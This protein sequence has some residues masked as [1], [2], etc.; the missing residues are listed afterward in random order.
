MHGECRRKE[1]VKKGMA[2]LLALCL[3]CGYVPPAGIVQA[4][5]AAADIPSTAHVNDTATAGDTAEDEVEDYFSIRQQ[6]EAAGH[7]MPEDISLSF[8]IEAAAQSGPLQQALYEGEAGILTD[9]AQPWVEFTVDIPT[10]GLYQLGSRYYTDDSRKTAPIRGLLIDGVSPYTEAQSIAFYSQFRDESAPRTNTLGDE[11][12]PQATA[13]P[14]WK[15]NWFFDSTGSV[16]SPLVFYMEQGQHVIRLDMVN[17][18]P[19]VIG[20]LIVASVENPPS[21]AEYRQMH[22]STN[23]GAYDKRFEAEDSM[24]YRN[25]SAVTLASHGDPRVS[26]SSVKHQVLNTVGGYTFRRGGQEVI[27]EVEAPAAGYY[28]LNFRVLQNF[29]GWQPSYRRITVNGTVPFAELESYAFAYNK[30]WYNAILSAPDGTPY[31]IWLE[32]G[33]NEIGLTVNFGVD[34]QVVTCFTDAIFALS[35]LV[36]QITMITGVSPDPNYNYRLDDNIPD[37]DEQFAAILALLEEARELLRSTA[38]HTTTMEDNIDSVAV[39][40]EKIRRR[41]DDIPGQL[42]NLSDSANSLGDW[43]TDLQSQALQIDY[44]QVCSPDVEIPEYHSNIFEVIWATL[45]SFAQS[46]TRDYDYIAAVSQDGE[47]PVREV[48]DVWIGRGTEWAEILKQRIDSDFTPQTGIAVRLNM[49]P[50]GQLS[51]GQLNVLLLAISSGNAPDVAMSVASNLPV[52]YAIRGAVSDLSAFEGYDRIA[53]RFLEQSLVPYQYDGG[54]WGM[55]ETMGFRVMF[56]RKDIFEDLSL[57]PPETWDELYNT[58]IPRLFETGRQVYVP[59]WMD[60]FVL[61]NGG[62]YYTP[63]GKRSALNTPE[64]YRGFEMYCNTYTLYGVPTSANFFNRFRQGEMPIG[65]EG[66]GMY[67]SLTSAAPE[68]NGLWG[69]TQIPGVRMEDGTVNR[70]T[71]GYAGEA[72][73]IL[74][75]SAKQQASFDFLNWWTSTEVQSEYASQVLSRIGAQARWMSANVEAFRSASWD[76]AH[77]EVITDSW[78]NLQEIPNVLGGYFT[79]RDVGN[80]WNRVILN[81]MSPRDSLELC[82]EDINKELTRRQ[83]QYAGN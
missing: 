37:L 82:Y 27:F 61:S 70:K 57:E 9:T 29:R 5:N 79:S 35:S 51:T 30:N 55:P 43:L 50:S 42:G 19:L 69:I 39:Q 10:A 20:E 49:I 17:G 46:F 26:P 38:S 77:L 36:Q 76:P 12:L 13:I 47:T 14:G 67:L 63:D 45:Y 53:D 64:A 23:T 33:K 73:M 54:V 16:A 4:E 71:G 1:Q 8:G 34:S 6:W 66:L 81:G 15:Q 22:E 44:I 18:Q 31:E 52:E 68:L 80:A 83:Q 25:D 40:L 56:Y 74:S 60:M 24:L 32:E 58:I 3:L 28:H 65:V 11:V 62:S 72:S 78:E 7:A 41:V 59:Q 21:Y 2:L 48:I 75:G